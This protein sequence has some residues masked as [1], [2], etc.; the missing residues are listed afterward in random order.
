MKAK[1]NRVLFTAPSSSSG[2]TTVVCSLLQLLVNQ[3][4]PVSAFKCGPD[5]IDPLFH[6]KIIGAGCRN[7]DLFFTDENTVNYLLWKN[8]SNSRLA[9]LEGVMGYY[10]GLGGNTLTASAYHLAKATNTPVV[11]VINGRGMSLSI[12]A[13]IKGFL[14][15][16]PQSQIA[17]VLLNQISP[18]MYP[19]LKTIIEE[20]LQLPVMGYLPQNPEFALESRHLGLVT[21]GEVANLKEKLQKMAVQAER[22]IDVCKIMELAQNAPK[23]TFT[24]P[25]L[26]PKGEPVRLGVAMDEAFCFYYQD[27]L[28]L[29]QELGAQ[30]VYFSPLRDK[31]LPTGLHGVYFGGGYPEL[32]V[33]QLSKNASFLNS[34]RQAAGGGLPCFGECGGFMYLHQRLQGEDGV[35]YPMSGLIE[36]ES[37]STGRLQRFGYANLTAM[38]DT[39]LLAKGE[40][41]PVHE[42]HYWDTT[43]PGAACQ[44]QKPG[45]QKSWPCVVN[46]GS[47]MAGYPHFYF[48]SNPT[49]A[50]RFLQHCR[51]YK[52]GEK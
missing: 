39:L 10:D 50:Y 29:L 52:E 42:F 21:A 5:Y 51:Q 7:L 48:Y 25:S 8:A 11:L 16:Q 26:P 34:L 22:T 1:V 49:M 15:Y 46:S 44:S 18:M 43:N 47:V 6:S 24:K 14:E 27:S 30:L 31:T 40:S 13:Q 3:N 20:Q 2:K 32:Y 28:D 33:R 41:V 12:V 9:V 36:G 45:Q 23:L 17:A 38:E 4:I 19:R 35:Y 37:F